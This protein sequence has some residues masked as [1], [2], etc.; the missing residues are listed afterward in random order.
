MSFQC[1]NVNV[2]TGNSVDLSSL[3]ARQQMQ[4]LVTEEDV[5]MQP[6]QEM[7]LMQL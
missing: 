5:R 3:V 4:T 6:S 1:V 7:L 2:I